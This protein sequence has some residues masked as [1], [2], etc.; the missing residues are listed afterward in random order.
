MTRSRGVWLMVLGLIASVVTVTANPASPAP[1]SGPAVE[2]LVQRA[3]SEGEM[4]L[5]VQIKE[6]GDGAKVA[7]SA[8]RSGGREVSTFEFMPYV[9]LAGNADT[10]RAL[11]RHPNVV[12]I[13]ED[14]PEPPALDSTLPV[15][16]ADSARALGWTGAGTTVAILDTGIDGDHPFFSDN[17][18]GNPGTS[19][20]LSQACFSD[21]ANNP[22]DNEFTL[23]PNGTP[24][25][26]TSAEVDGL[27]NCLDGTDN[28]C[29][30]G[31]HVAGIAAGDGTAVPGAPAAGVAPD[32][33][34]VA[35][36]VFTRFTAVADCNP[37][38]APC[39][40]SAPSRQIAGLNRVAVLA[41]ANPGWNVTA[42][43]MSLGGGN[44]AAACDG[45]NRKP[46]IDALLAAGIATVISSGNNGFLNAVGAPACI[47][48]AVAVGNTTD[49][50]LVA[51]NSNRG[52]LLDL[53][54]PGTDVDSSVIATFGSKSGTSM[55]A[56]H[57]TGAFAVLRQ[58]YPARTIAQLLGDL[59]AT[60][61]PI[62]YATNM[63]GTT[64]ETTPRIDLLAALL[65]VDPSAICAALPAVPPAGAI[66]ATPGVVT[67]GTAGDDLIYGLGGDDRIVGL[68][69][70]DTIVGLG[71]NDQ[72]TGSEGD[73][74]ICGGAGNDEL[75][76]GAGNDLLSGDTGTNEDLAGGT[77]DDLLVGGAGGV[78]VRLSGGAGTDTCVAAVNPV[79]QSATCEL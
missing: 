26:L 8:R 74:V 14:I 18:G 2:S 57:V 69:G 15:I 23:C 68:G 20:I 35:I 77:G 10:I 79:S 6:P 17:N 53:L 19:R 70:N 28:I 16:S 38:P 78:L 71:G 66:V 31:I 24:T 61:V 76:G 34:I 64:T 7:R 9:T 42:V 5:V 13:T 44:N 25:D 36:Q 39:V 48:T 63:A 11:A 37:N 43:N 32:A 45:N 3:S 21:A 22:A 60:G 52:P 75:F 55:S 27:A 62:T 33:G 41:A 59:Q 46:A 40:K 30:H 47:S 4:Q 50:D 54:A 58:A 72:L 29:D 49:A 56:P 73:D 67:S 12:G 1:V 65:S 51:A